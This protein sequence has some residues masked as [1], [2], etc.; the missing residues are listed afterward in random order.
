VAL[1]AIPAGLSMVIRPQDGSVLQLQTQWLDG[2]PF[3]DFLIPGLFSG[4]L[5]FG[6]LLS[7]LAQ[8]AGLAPAPM[9]SLVTP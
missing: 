6:T 4:V 1:G 3:G 5:G 8:L 2:S 7:A 9:L